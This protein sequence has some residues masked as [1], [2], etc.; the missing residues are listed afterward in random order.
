MKYLKKLDIKLVKG[1]YKS[2]VKGKVTKAEQIYEVFKN[3]KDQNQETIIGVFLDNDLEV[4][5]YDVLGVGTSTEAIV[6]AKEVYSHALILKSDYF[7]LIHNHPKGDPNPS[8]SDKEVIRVL[9]DFEEKLEIKMLDFIIIGDM[10]VNKR[11]KNFWSL[12]EEREGG[13]YT[14]GKIRS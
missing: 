12:F 1:E 14:L 5:A 6:S 4:R 2:P 3:I 7:I 11:K 9:E 8:D 13:E 10:A